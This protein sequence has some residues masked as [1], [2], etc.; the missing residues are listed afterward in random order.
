MITTRVDRRRT[1]TRPWATAAPF[2]T[3]VAT[4]VVLDWILFT[5]SNAA[6]TL[7]LADASRGF[8]L[9]G[10][11]LGVFLLPAATLTIHV[12]AR[13]G[14][15]PAAV[16]AIVGIVSWAGWYLFVGAV[17]VA[18]GT[19]GLW[20]EG[21]GALLVL[22]AIAGAAFAALGVSASSDPPRRIVT[23]LAGVVG[24]LIVAGCFVTVGWWGQAT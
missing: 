11:I 10:P 24:L 4:V 21:F 8:V 9:L 7:E 2:V 12:V 14:S 18:A 5:S 3:Y 23:V 16:R 20:P 13:L 17:V 6:R 22:V 15:T 19:I 1:P